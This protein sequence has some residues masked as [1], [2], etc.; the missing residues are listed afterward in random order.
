MKKLLLLHGALGAKVQFNEL[1]PKLTRNYEVHTMNFSGHGGK[2]I[3][4]EP[5]SM[6]MF[7]RDIE[8]YLT[9]NKID[10]I[11]IFGYSM[12]G[13]AALHSAL[14]SPGRIKKIFILATKF[15]WTALVAEREVKML[16]A[17][18]IKQKVPKFA[19]EL[20]KRHSEDKWVKVMEK[21]AEM[22][23]ELGELG[24]RNGGTPLR[25]DDINND[26]LIGIGDRDKM[27]SLEETIAAYRALPHGKLIVLPGI[28]HP[29]EM[30]DSDRLA[31]EIERFFG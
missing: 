27:V 2:D 22:M 16:D 4:N 31:W 10:E 19:Q 18:K 15:E 3:P 8:S 29:I 5:F 17:Q 23:L 20:T 1:A 25:L 30:V 13:Y 12:G 14:N 26:V 24:G 11:D 9:E 7:A 21:T 6:E 28:P